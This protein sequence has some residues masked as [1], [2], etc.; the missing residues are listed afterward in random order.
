MV[1]LIVTSTTAYA[2]IEDYL[3]PNGKQGSTIDLSDEGEVVT[4]DGTGNVIDGTGEIKPQNMVIV[5]LD[6]VSVTFPDQQPIINKDNRTIIP[7]RFLAQD[8]KAVVNWDGATQT[9][10][11]QK[12]DKNIT[13]KI[14]ESTAFVN[15]QSVTFDTSASL[16]NNRTMV[17]LRFVSE[18]LDCDVRWEQDT[19]SVYVT[20]RK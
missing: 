1:L 7:V 8:M 20:T 9:V 10:T 16:L 13:L 19:R 4:T 11:I 12:G 5:F 2:G 15:G 3:D 6:R 18:T 14:G 17:P